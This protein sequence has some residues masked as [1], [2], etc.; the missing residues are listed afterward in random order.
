MTS[1]AKAGR[2]GK[3]YYNA[4]TH[5]S[6]SWVEVKRA[7]DVSVPND[8]DKVEIDDR[9]SEEKKSVGGGRSKE[10]SFGYTHQVG[11]DSVFSV[12]LD[13]YNNNTAVEFAVMDGAIGTAGSK[14][15]RGYYE[16]FKLEN[17]QEL[18]SPM[19]YDVD[20]SLTE[21]EEA[22]EIIEP[23]HSVVS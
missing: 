18:N 7:K 10:L 6:P 4:G 13:S 23:D 2:K 5:A 8:K 14:G 22:S 17:S 1:R 12:L 20:C 19:A 3:L 21:H 15:W 16:V 11:T 9:N